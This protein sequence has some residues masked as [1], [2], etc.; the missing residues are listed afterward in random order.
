MNIFLLTKLNVCT[1]I[2]RIF[3]QPIT[4]MVFGYC[5]VSL[6]LAALAFTSPRFCHIASENV[7]D[8]FKE[9]A[10]VAVA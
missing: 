5:Y 3:F 10:I 2:W 7:R 1:N 8:R 6:K 9:L 4:I